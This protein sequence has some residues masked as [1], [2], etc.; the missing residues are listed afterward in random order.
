MELIERDDL[1]AALRSQ[2]EH[3]SQ[4]EGR[5]V[6]VSG[7]AGIGKTSLIKS[8]C[9]EVRNESNIYQGICDALFTPRPLAP[10]YDVL[11]QLGKDIPA[12]NIDTT[13]RTAFFTNFLQGLS[14]RRKVNVIVFEDIHWADEATL[15]FIKFLARRISQFKCLFVLTYRDTEIH[16]SHALRNIMGQLNPDSF[17][18]IGLLPLSKQAVEKMAEERGYN[19]EDVYR[20]TNGNPFYVTEIL[21]SYSLGVPDNIKDSILS[22]YNKMNE[23][24]KHV[25]EILSVLPTAFEMSYLDKLDESYIPAV[26][27]CIDAKILI[28]DKERI[29]F[30]HELYRRTIES[31]LSPL[32]RITLN[33]KILDLLLESFEENQATER[34]IHHAKNANEYDLVV[35]YAPVAAKQAASIGAH[36][37]AARLYQTAIEYYQGHDEDIL[38]Q[39]YEQYAYECYLTNQAK[40]A[41]IYTSRALDIWKKKNDIEQIGSSM[42]FLS[43]LWWWSGN[44]NRAES[45]AK[46]AIEVLESQPSSKA[47][48]M[49]YSNLAQLKML[50]EKLDEC[51][52]WGGKAITIA[53]ELNDEE[54]LSHALNNVGTVEMAHGSVEKGN[55]LLQQSLAIALKNSYNEHAARAYTNLG[56]NWVMLKNYKEGEKFFEEGIQYCEER[57]LDAWISYMLSWKAMLKLETGHWKE[58]YNIAEGL[59]K[60]EAQT[61]IVRITALVVVATIEMRR[62]EMMHVVTCWMRKQW[63]RKVWSRK[64]FFLFYPLYWNMNG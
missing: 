48:A 11:L 52:Y 34:I 2:F 10:L 53:K 1:L 4:G 37:E 13:N 43:R 35:K 7:E 5:C 27:N 44:W 32:A 23:K 8:F 25:W 36:V 30:K 62:G 31:S 46:E 54:T 42:R 64:E 40:E 14:D 3:V 18:R 39:F 22:V 61:P 21:A 51:L 26:Q 29:F 50:T 55:E 49:A 24:T 28:V 63:L 19:G 60:N 15:D 12:G 41:I 17:T 56:C 58:A 9:N 59:L 38:I 33:K 20:I 45:F 47:K 16:F 57:D 6:F